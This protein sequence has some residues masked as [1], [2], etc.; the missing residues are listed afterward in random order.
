[1]LKLCTCL[2]LKLFCMGDTNG[3]DIAQ[4]THEAILREA[5]CL[6]E[7]NTLIHGRVFPCS[8]TLEGL[9]IDDH[10]AM[11]VVPKKGCRDRERYEVTYHERLKGKIQCP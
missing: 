2:L 9:Y 6:A 8:D 3:V 1:M 7:A 4:A 10:L 11:Q 5:G